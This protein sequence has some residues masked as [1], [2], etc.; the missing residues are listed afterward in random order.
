M[1]NKTERLENLANVD[2]QFCTELV[3]SKKVCFSFYYLFC[4]TRQVCC[5]LSLIPKNETGKKIDLNSWQSMRI[6][7]DKIL[8]YKW[9]WEKETSS[10]ILGF[11]IDF[12]SIGW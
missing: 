9:K 10:N 6:R 7:Q 1:A 2:L 11:H 8:V 3:G 5:L 4:Y 12:W